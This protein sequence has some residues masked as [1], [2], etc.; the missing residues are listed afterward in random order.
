MDY[1]L[2]IY[3]KK[4]TLAIVTGKENIRNSIFPYSCHDNQFPW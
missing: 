2:N 3:L 1:V 4:A